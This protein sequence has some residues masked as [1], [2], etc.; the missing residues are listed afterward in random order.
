MSKKLFKETQNFHNWA[1]LMGLVISFALVIYRI[2]DTILYPPSFLF[3][4]M[5]V[6]AVML[7]SIIVG[8]WYMFQLRLKISI[9]EKSIRFRMEPFHS[10]KKKIYWEEIDTVEIVETPEI[11][12]WHGGNIT[13]NHEKRFSIYGRNG[14]HLVTKDGQE[15]F[16]GSRRLNELRKVI[17]E[18]LN[19]S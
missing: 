15:Y 7:V 6:Y 8:F 1:L 5:L 18:V 2:I 13:F 3:L 17:S 19:R 9:T 4:N 12:Q 16:L 14:L 11:A 10:K